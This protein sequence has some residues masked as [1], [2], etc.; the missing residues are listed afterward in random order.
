MQHCSIVKVL[1]H[2]LLVCVQLCSALW[3]LKSRYALSVLGRVQDTRYRAGGVV[4]GGLLWI[5]KPIK[6]AL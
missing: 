2:G 3:T 5:I 6:D 4:G 1:K